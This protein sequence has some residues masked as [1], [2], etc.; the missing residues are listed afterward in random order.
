M[1]R[2]YR[3]V[4][5]PAKDINLREK[6]PGGEIVGGELTD[7]GEGVECLMHQRHWLAIIGVLHGINS[8]LKTKAGFIKRAVGIDDRIP[9]AVFAELVGGDA[10]EVNAR[11]RT[12]A[13]GSVEIQIDGSNDI[14][15]I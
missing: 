9:T 6:E 15:G 2:F 3:P 4:G 11:S 7:A 8:I 12:G 1:Q 13:Q 5:L 14:V 10:G